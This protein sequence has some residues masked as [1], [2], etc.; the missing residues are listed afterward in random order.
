MRACRANAWGK[1]SRRSYP[2]ETF[3][4]PNDVAD[5]TL[6]F[7]AVFFD[8]DYWN[9]I[10]T[11]ADLNEAEIMFDGKYL[12]PAA[13]NSGTFHSRLRPKV[14]IPSNFRERPDDAGC[15]E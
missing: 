5:G 1:G 15:R 9:E 10:D 2:V 4:T 11:M 7:E 3:K 13:R 8:P 6:S 12:E 14:Q